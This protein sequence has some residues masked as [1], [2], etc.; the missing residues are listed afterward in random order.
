MTTS[1]TKRTQSLHEKLVELSQGPRWV[2]GKAYVDMREHSESMER[3]NNALREQLAEK[4]AALAVCVE[5]IQRVMSDTVLDKQDAD[6]YKRIILV[7][8]A[9]LGETTVSLPESAKQAAKVLEAAN[10]AV[11]AIEELINESRGVMGLHRN[12]NIAPWDELRS[13]GRYELWL[14]PF[15]ELCQAVQ[16]G[17]TIVR[18]GLTDS[19]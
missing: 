16:D 9:W 19:D 12:G 10:K 13:G 3:E 6:Y 11:N 4:E 8:V 18:V 2:V 7:H 1:D 5:S 17:K 14:L 15:D